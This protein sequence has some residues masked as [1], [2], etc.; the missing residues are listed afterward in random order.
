MALTV[1]D[2]L[3]VFKNPQITLT[4]VDENGDEVAKIYAN[5]KDVLN[6]E[7]SAMEIKLIKV[8]NAQN[9]TI[10]VKSENL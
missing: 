2:F 1:S 10:T 8:D 9:V 6:T 4:I 5:G 7:I 3:K